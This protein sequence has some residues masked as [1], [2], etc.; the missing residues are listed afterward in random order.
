MSPP[1]GMTVKGRMVP[2]ESSGSKRRTGDYRRIGMRRLPASGISPDGPLKRA[3]RKI[4]DSAGSVNPV[5]A[6]CR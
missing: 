2:E 5:L 6:S 1:Q 4:T 3:P